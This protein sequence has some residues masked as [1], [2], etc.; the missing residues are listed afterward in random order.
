[1]TKREIKHRARD[2]RWDIDEVS[3]KKVL[4]VI[5]DAINEY[6]EDATL[7]ISGDEVEIEILVARLETD[8]EYERRQ[9]VEQQYSELRAKQERAE[10]ERLKA[11]FGE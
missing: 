2:I 3:L 4:Q 7:D 5:Q 1:M 6:G 9:Q 11:K 10:Y 8:E